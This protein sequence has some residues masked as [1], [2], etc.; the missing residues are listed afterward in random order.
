MDHE[1]RIQ[2][3]IDDLKSQERTNVAATA[4]KYNVA[5]RTLTHR[6]KGETGLN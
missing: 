6:F 5:R 4:R 3:A 1:A 2:A